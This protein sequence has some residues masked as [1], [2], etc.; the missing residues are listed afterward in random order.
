MTFQETMDWQRVQAHHISRL[1][2]LGDKLAARLIVAYRELH[3][4]QLNPA[5]QTVWMQ[6][7]DDYCRRDLTNVTRVLLQ[8]R[9]G[10]KAPKQLKRLDS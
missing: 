2:K 3:A 5:K 4:D 9:F 8:D 6:V 1:A 10:H 7:C